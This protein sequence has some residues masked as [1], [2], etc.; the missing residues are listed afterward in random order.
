MATGTAQQIIA[1]KSPSFAADPRLSDFVTLAADFVSQSAYG[2]KYQHALALVVLHWLTLDAQQGGNSSVSGGGAGGGIKSEKEG[3]LARTFGSSS[4]SASTDDSY[5][6]STVFGQ[7]LVSLRSHC[8]F[9][10]HHRVS[11]GGVS[12]VS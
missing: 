11:L 5:W 2:T 1:V 6:A 10:P 12:R 4:S 8:I 7:E 9:A 3:D